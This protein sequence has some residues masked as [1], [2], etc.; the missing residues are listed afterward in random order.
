MAD[1]LSVAASV[2]G[3]LTAAAQISRT[4][5]DITKR[6]KK[7]P[8]ECKDARM[9]VDDIRNILS[10]LQLFVLGAAKASRSRSSLILVEQVVTT[11]AATVTTF[12]EL[13]VFVET[14]ESDERMGLMDRL[15]WVSKEKALNELIQK[16]QLHKS[17]MGLMLTILTW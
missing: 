4:L 11:L 2:V 3:L 5:Y 1:P 16:L 8:K 10:Q 17:S 9:E 14:L 13:D 6:A 7:A 12:S 15:R